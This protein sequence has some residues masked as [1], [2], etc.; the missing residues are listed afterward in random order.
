[1]MR[2]NGLLKVLGAS[3]LALCI[4]V[5]CDDDVKTQKSTSGQLGEITID[6][7]DIGAYQPFILECPVTLGHNLNEEH[8]SWES[9]QIL[10]LGEAEI[11]DGKSH[12]YVKGLKAG[13]Y[14]VTCNLRANGIDEKTYEVTKEIQV[15][16]KATDIRNNYWGDSKE[17]T[18][19]NLQYYSSRQEIDGAFYIVE[20]DIYGRDLNYSSEITMGGNKVSDLRTV[21]YNFNEAGKLNMITYACTLGEFERDGMVAGIA[22]RQRHLTNLQ[23]FANPVYG[24]QIIEG[25]SLTEEET[26]LAE[27]FKA[28]ELETDTDGMLEQAVAD[29][30]L[31]I[32]VDMTGEKSLLRLSLRLSQGGDVLMYEVYTPKS[33]SNP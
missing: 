5:S 26:D 6:R 9:P 8:I 16:V 19:R 30:R 4:L 20:R 29:G 32:Y 11:K 27:K 7:T 12:V 13:D 24:Y 1:M 2:T 14:T 17:E 3:V 21:I 25:Q 10:I 23:G 31:R 28:G 33:T 22:T 15:H 18:L